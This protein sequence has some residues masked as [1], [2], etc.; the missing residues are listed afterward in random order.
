MPNDVLPSVLA[1]LAAERVRYV[2]MVGIE[3]TPGNIDVREYSLIM[4]E[5]GLPPDD[6]TPDE[7]MQELRDLER[8]KTKAR[9]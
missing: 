2:V 3:R 9:S 6:M 8:R 4:D 7:D 5:E 1:V